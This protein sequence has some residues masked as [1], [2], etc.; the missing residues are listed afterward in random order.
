MEFALDFGVSILIFWIW[1]PLTLEF[2]LWSL[3]FN[4]PWI[5]HFAYD[6]WNF[7]HPFFWHFDL[8]V[9]YVIAL[10][11]VIVLHVFSLGRDCLSILTLYCVFFSLGCNYPSICHWFLCFSLSC[12]YPLILLLI[13]VL[14]LW[15]KITFNFVLD[16]ANFFYF[17]L[18]LHF[19]L[20]QS[21]YIFWLFTIRNFII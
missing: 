17:N 7:D 15:D 11:F 2:H 8:D 13:F 4:H 3:G 20:Y 9:C 1:L 5:W 12:N 14:F 6:L 21:F 10:D 19:I 16:V 18:A